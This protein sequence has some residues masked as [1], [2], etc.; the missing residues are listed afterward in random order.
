MLRQLRR[1]VVVVMVSALE[2]SRRDG[3]G[4]GKRATSRRRSR[5]RG[6]VALGLGLVLAIGVTGGTPSIAAVAA[7]APAGVA[8]LTA[9]PG[10]PTFGSASNALEY[11]RGMLTMAASRTVAPDLPAP[12]PIETDPTTVGRRSRKRDVVFGE[13][14][15]QEEAGQLSTSFELS[16]G[17]ITPTSGNAEVLTGSFDGYACPDAK[18]VVRAEAAG[19]ALFY[20]AGVIDG[21]QSFS[22][23][24]EIQV[25]DAAEIENLEFDGEF[26]EQVVGA[27]AQPGN[28][29]MR[30][31]LQYDQSVNDV[32]GHI[33][34]VV[35][36][37]PFDKADGKK[38]AERVG[39]KAQ[40]LA[41]AAARKFAR[42]WR[43]GRTCVRIEVLSGGPAGPLKRRQKVRIKARGVATDAA[44]IKKPLEGELIDGTSKLDAGNGKIPTAFDY[45]GPKA[46]DTGTVL[47]TSRSRRGIGT[48]TLVY[49]TASD[50]RLDSEFA[51]QH[52]TATKCDGLA[53]RWDFEVTSP[54]Y[55]SRGPAFFTIESEPEEGRSA[56]AISNL[57]EFYEPNV[58]VGYRETFTLTL[59][60]DGADT[61]WGAPAGSPALG[62]DEILSGGGIPVEAG[63]FCKD[64]D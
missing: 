19:S 45:V 16:I 13:H 22:I 3:D 44:E 4:R 48:R 33:A 21:Q 34:T 23:K 36:S 50:Y 17:V 49:S 43:D 14:V 40:A 24:L 6:V 28:D 31:T 63:D 41:E 61:A 11:L 1:F 26:G 53:G 2:F 64:A 47:L 51:G 37:G 46:K 10:P 5:R 7:A 25:N 42:I 56:T 55:S 60:A 54:T 62:I 59:Y 30:S 18:G 52:W 8:P 15:A 57:V 29:R 35:E 32:S 58:R 9:P 39:E 38:V 12:P 20:R 27:R